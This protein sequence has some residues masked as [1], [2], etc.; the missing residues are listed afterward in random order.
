MGYY[1]QA[2]ELIPESDANRQRVNLKRAVAYARWT[3]VADAA[4]ALRAKEREE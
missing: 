1:N 2:L 4:Q 3:H